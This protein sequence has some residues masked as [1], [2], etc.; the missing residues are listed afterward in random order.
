MIKKILATIFKDEF[1]ENYPLSEFTTFKTGGKADFIVFPKNIE[2]TKEILKISNDFALPVLILGKGSNIL[3]SDK[4][5]KGIVLCTLKLNQIEILNEKI[6]SEPGVKLSTLLN[7]SFKKKL[8]GLEFLIG[9]PGTVGGAV[10]MNAGLKEKWISGKIEKVEVIDKKN[11]DTITLSKNEI[12]FGYR[13]SGLENYFIWKTHF[14]LEKNL[15]EKIKKKLQFYIR[16]KI[17]KQP[18]FLPSAGSIFKNPEGKF[19][20][21]LIEKCGL[22]GYKIGNVKI[23]EKHANFILNLGNATSSQIYQLIKLIQNQVKKRYNIELE[24]EIKIIGEF[25]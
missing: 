21:E 25:E 5:F 16:E 14:K 23:S 3:I 1:K 6:I 22:K 20:G 2:E 7:V 24:P 4:G 11:L 18:L 9:I 12:L 19:A 8:S 17:K 15:P 13:K 10:L